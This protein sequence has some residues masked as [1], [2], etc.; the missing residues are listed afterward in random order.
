MAYA[1]ITDEPKVA[2]IQTEQ[3]FIAMKPNGPGTWR[4]NDVSVSLNPQ[5]NGI[6]IKITAGATKVKRVVFR[7]AQDI[8]STV[9]IM[10]SAWERSYG[11]LE[12]KGIVPERIMPWYFLIYDGDLTRGYGVKTGAG[13]F[14]FWQVTRYDLT[15]CVDIRCGGKGVMLDGRELNAAAAISIE[16]GGDPFNVSKS[17]CAMMCEKPLKPK[18]P[19]YGGN[20]WY[21]AYGE[22]S[23]QEIM[24]DSMLI[25]SLAASNKNR[26]FMVIDDGWQLC[27]HGD[28]NGG[29]WKYSNTKF[30]DMRRLCEDM[31]KTGVRPGIWY[32]PLYTAE[33]VPNE[34][35]LGQVG[36]NQRLDPSIKDVLQMVSE[37]I[38]RLK[39][40]GFEL[41]KHDFSTFDLFSRWGFQMFA[42]I[43]DNDW[44]F[45]DIHRTSAEIVLDFYR[46]IRE[47]AG[48]TMV[49]GCN[50]IGHLAAGLVEIQR[51]GE[52]TSGIEWEK[53]RMM[54]INT[55][56]FNMP[57]HKTFFDIDADC[58]AITDRINWKMSEQWLQLVAKSGTP[59]F[60]S[61]DPKCAGKVQKEALQK[62]FKISAECIEAGKPLDWMDTTCPSSWLLEGHKVD[63]NWNDIY[64]DPIRKVW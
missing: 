42:E 62:A 45:A 11:D 22:S 40:W 25:S 50:T 49:I 43:T 27:H 57:Q 1:K 35:V 15:L 29:P 32:R 4:H 12:W 39:N 59:L 14:C 36:L 8:D 61:I 7:W 20:N 26:P 31:K 19:V 60:V 64:R 30:G 53:S 56:A 52:D 33:K 63:F 47:S 51:S 24:N 13:S 6:N 28:S 54:G 34:W 9:K 58:V 38:K 48:D 37:D 21:Y 41:I 16:K 5:K 3:D 46:T 10:G 17:F 23:Y 18:Y 2:M 55:L 44:S